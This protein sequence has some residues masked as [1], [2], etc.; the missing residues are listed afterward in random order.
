[1]IHRIQGRDHQN[2]SDPTCSC[3]SHLFWFKGRV[4]DDFPVR[5]IRRNASRKVPELSGSVSRWIPGSHDPHAACLSVHVALPNSTLWTISWARCP[6]ARF[7][8]TNPI[9]EFREVFESIQNRKVRVGSSLRPKPS[10]LAA[11]RNDHKIWDIN[12]SAG[13]QFIE[14]ENFE[15]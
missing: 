11:T 13:I 14:D 2:G 10:P 7:R 3:P 6:S 1:M 4:Y 5:G 9:Q 12:L 15:L 8:G